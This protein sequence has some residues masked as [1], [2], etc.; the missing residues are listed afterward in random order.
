[1][2][3]KYILCYRNF[4]V[5]KWKKH[6]RIIA[7]I[8]N[9]KFL[10]QLYPIFNENNRKLVKNISKHVNETQPFDIWN[11]IISC[12]LNNISRKFEI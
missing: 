6:R 5:H 1:M 11:Y 9:S 2:T 12:N 8:F 3:L 10:D 7:T 4:T